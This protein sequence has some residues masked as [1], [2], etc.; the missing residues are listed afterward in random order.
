MEHLEE[1]A[2]HADHG[3]EIGHL[4]IGDAVQHPIP[5]GPGDVAQLGPGRVQAALLACDFDLA[6]VDLL[7][8]L[9]QVL[10]DEV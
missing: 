4:G 2:D 10:G 6:A 5:D 7:Q 9:G 8:Q 3:D 1:D